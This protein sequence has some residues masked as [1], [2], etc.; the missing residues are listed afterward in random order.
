M[1]P[2]ISFIT[3]EI[4]QKLPNTEG[5]LISAPYPTYK[6]ELE[7]FKEVE[8]VEAMQ[9]FVKSVRTTRSELSIG[10]E[11]KL[12]V[13]LKAGD[14][15]KGRDFVLDNKEL[16]GTFIGSSTFTVDLNNSSD[17]SGFIPVSG[18]SFEAFISIKEAIDVDFEIKKISGEIEKA[19]KALEATLKKLSNENFINNAKAEAIEKEKTK[20]IEFETTIHQGQK[21]LEILGGLK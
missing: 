19:Q 15:F 18:L 3:E 5:M 20:K 14:S 13:I 10:S 4:Y 12:P 8:Q 11:R 7:F 9:S 1:H 17:I 6:D 16:I 21:H 2:F